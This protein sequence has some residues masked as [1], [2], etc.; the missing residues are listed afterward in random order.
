MIALRKLGIVLK[1]V[2]AFVAVAGIVRKCNAVAA[3]IYPK[4]R[5]RR[6]LFG[7]IK[8]TSSRGRIQ[9]NARAAV[10]RDDVSAIRGGAADLIQFCVFGDQD[11]VS[12]VAEVGSVVFVGA[13]QVVDNL[14]VESHLVLAADDYAGAVVA[15]DDVA[16]SG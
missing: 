13:D 3:Q 6:Y 11:S 9:R 4:M 8:V 5:F 7:S 14:V 10:V 12:V 2:G 15:A 16:E 1:V